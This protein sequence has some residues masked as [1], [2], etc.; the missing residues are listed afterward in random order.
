MISRARRI[1][2]HLRETAAELDYA[3][4]RLLE[5]RTGIPLTPETER[6]LA[7]VQIA[8]LEALYARPDTDAEPDCPRE[9]A[10]PREPE[11][12]EHWTA[13]PPARRSSARVPPS[14]RACPRA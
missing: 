7:R 9:P 8:R 12:H 10:R 5:I 13:Q 4:R 3:Q 2:R 11:S 1:V 14:A 6:A